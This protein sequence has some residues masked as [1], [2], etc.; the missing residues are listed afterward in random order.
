MFGSI[1]VNEIIVKLVKDGNFRNGLGSKLLILCVCV[2]FQ[3]VTYAEISF[4]HNN[5]SGA[6]PRHNLEMNQTQYAQVVVNSGSAAATAPSLSSPPS[7]EY[8]LKMKKRVLQDGTA[9]VH[10]AQDCKK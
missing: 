2:C 4:D 5:K 9:A 8:T 1:R 10:Y 6:P 3:V 7:Y